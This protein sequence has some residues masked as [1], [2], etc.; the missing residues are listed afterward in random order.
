VAFRMALL[1]KRKSGSWKARKAIP[2]D[3]RED[4][5]ALYGKSLEEIF[6]APSTDPRPRAEMKHREWLMEVESRIRTLR[7][8]KRGGARDLTQREAQALAGQ[9]YQWFVAQHEENPGNPQHW[10]LSAELLEDAI[11]DATL[12]YE[13]DPFLDQTQRNQEP[14][15]RKQ[16]HPQ[17]T[18]HADTAQFLVSRGEVL[19]EE[20]MVAFL[21][22]VL[23]DYISA[24]YLLKRRAQGDYSRDTLPQT[25]PVFEPKKPKAASGLTAMQLFEAYLPAAGYSAGSVTS[26]RAVFNALEAHLGGRTVDSLSD[27]EAQRWVSSLRTPERSPRTVMNQRCGRHARGRSKSA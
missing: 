10:E 6:H 13:F 18:R 1:R 16:V 25:F 22:C 14:A 15:V 24:C 7:A 3:V 27:D 9:W 8:K 20:A 4:Y 2:T 26:R 11:R 21:D 23:G 12:E 19:A 5:H 17:L